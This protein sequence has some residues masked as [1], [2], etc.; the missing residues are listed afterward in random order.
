MEMHILLATDGSETAG[1]ARAHILALPWR[2]PVHVTVMTAIEVPHPAFTSLTPDAR[3]AYTSALD[4]LHRDAQRRAAD[5]VCEARQVLGPHVGSVITRAHEGPPGKAIVGMAAACR[6]DLVAVGSR[7]LGTVAGFLLGSV[8]HYVVRHAA[9]SVLVAK[10]PP[11]P[12]YR[13]LLALDGSAHAE[14]ALQWLCR[15]ALSPDTAVCVVIVAEPSP[16]LSMRED[17]ELDGPQEEPDWGGPEA[18][19]TAAEEAV[20]VAERRLRGSG[21]RVTG[22]VR[23]GQATSELLAAIHEFEPH[24]FVLGAQGRHSARGTELGHVARRLVDH[25]PCS[26]LIVRP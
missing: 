23:C 11:P 2:T 3:D 10:H 21:A 20:A 19:D 1:L 25:I 14:A 5:T 4:A 22:A 12:A 8:S 18:S 15:L 13:V 24:L 17:A 26:A 6:A 7:G 16:A 9:C